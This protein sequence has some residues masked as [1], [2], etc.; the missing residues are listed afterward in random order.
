MMSSSVVIALCAVESIPA[1]L[2]GQQHALIGRDG[3]VTAS[4]ESTA[5]VLSS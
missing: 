1:D 4:A 2:C 3:A 5:I